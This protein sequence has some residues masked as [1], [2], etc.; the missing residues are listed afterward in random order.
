LKTGVG[1]PPLVGME[2]EPLVRP[3][4][5][6]GN[7]MIRNLGGGKKGSDREASG[8]LRGATEKKTKEGES[9]FGRGER[10]RQPYDYSRKEKL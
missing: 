1:G 3:T 5:Y 2:Q 6:S 7:R 9:I 10:S 4:I 8:Y